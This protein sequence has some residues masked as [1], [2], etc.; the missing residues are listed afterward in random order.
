[1]FRYSVDIPEIGKVTV[2]IKLDEIA[3][4]K[5]KQRFSPH[6]HSQFF[7][8]NDRHFP[9]IGA[10]YGNRKWNLSPEDYEKMFLYELNSFINEL[11]FRLYVNIV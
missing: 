9:L 8:N 11:K 3:E 6:L 4:K 10:I 7:Q 2:K 1:M 5:L